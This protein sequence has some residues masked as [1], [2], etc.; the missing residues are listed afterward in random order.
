MWHH[1]CGDSAKK[2]RCTKV[3]IA[4]VQQQQRAD[5]RNQ[6]WPSTSNQWREPS[7]KRRLALSNWLPIRVNSNG[8]QTEWQS[9]VLIRLERRRHG[10]ITRH[11]VSEIKAELAA[12]SEQPHFHY[13]SSR[14]EQR[15][16][17]AVGQANSS[18]FNHVHHDR[19]IPPLL[20]L[21][22]LQSPLYSGFS[23]A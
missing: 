11:R 5:N 18:N 23:A 4:A 6:Q 1:R 19:P 15:P 7:A 21:F 14:K 17:A 13:P 20:L 3:A 12:S 9:A 22:P 2:E 10:T 16:F 8:Q